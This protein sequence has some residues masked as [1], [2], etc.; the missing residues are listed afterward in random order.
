[1]NSLQH[2]LEKSWSKKTSSDPAN[3][4]TKN[5]AWGQ[6]AV[7][8]LVQQLYEGGIITRA[9]VDGDPKNSHYYLDNHRDDYTAK[10][11][12]KGTKLTKTSIHNR[13]D[14]LKNPDTKKRFDLLDKAVKKI[15]GIPEREVHLDNDE[16]KSGRIIPIEG[17][18]LLVNGK[19]S[20]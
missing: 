3:W 1:M 19:P 4:S 17:S 15:F 18:M 13:S 14:L 9:I 5:P 2:A 16:P 6:C 12:P 10:Q 11:F 8:T 7:T 20:E